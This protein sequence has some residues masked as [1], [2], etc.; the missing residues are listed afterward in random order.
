MSQLGLPARL[1]MVQSTANALRAQDFARWNPPPLLD[2]Q[3]A[4]WWLDRQPDLFKAKRKPLAA[5][6]KNA[7]DPKVLQTHFDEFKEVVVKYGITK[8]DTWNFDETGYRMDISRFDWIV[9]VDPNR[10]IYFKDPDM[11][12][13]FQKTSAEISKRVSGR[14]AL[15]NLTLV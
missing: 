9:T 8:N 4:K 10:I 1:H 13:D 5:E 15:H 7:H 12:D 3:W 2:A 11:H 6:R 14:L